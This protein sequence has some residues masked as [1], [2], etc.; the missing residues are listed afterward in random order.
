MPSPSTSTHDS[1]DHVNFGQGSHSQHQDQEEEEEVDEIVN[2]ILTIT[3]EGYESP[4]S[5]ISMIE[6]Y[7][8]GTC[9]LEI[10]AVAPRATKKKFSLLEKLKLIVKLFEGKCDNEKVRNMMLMVIDTNDENAFTDLIQDGSIEDIQKIALMIAKYKLSDVLQ[11]KNE[12]DQNALHLCII[13]GYENILKVFIKLGARVD[14]ADIFGQTPLHLAAQEDSMACLKALLSK[15]AISVNEMNDKGCTPLSLCVSNNNLSMTKLLIVTGA[16]PSIK[17]P[18]NGFNCL[19]VAVNVQQP[20]LE[21]IRYLIEID[22]TMLFCESNTGKNVRQL[23]IANN[24]L[25]SIIDFIST[26]Y[27]DVEELFLDGKCLETLC[28]IFD[29]HNNWKVFVTLMDFDDK[30]GEWELLDS[31]SQALFSHLKVSSW[32][33]E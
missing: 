15:P 10:D 8:K 6:D 17:N 27:D 29:R 1:S 3:S 33:Q 31:P 24:L 18:T 14:Q 32:R 26:F 20:K 19:H 7:L 28:E 9:N 21:M 25:P 11:F 30:I 23:A 12:F 5:N 4:S 13:N 16:I 22:P 2:L